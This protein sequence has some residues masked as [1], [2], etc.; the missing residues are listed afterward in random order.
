MDLLLVGAGHAHLYVVKHAAELLAAGYRVTLLSPR[1]FH[2]SG[3]ASAAAAGELPA[4][5]GRIDVAALAGHAGVE[6]HDG[7]LADLD[8]ETRTAR[9]GD[10]TELTYDVI[11]LNIGSVVA[12][13]DMTV[14]DAVLRVKPLSALESLGAHLADP[15]LRGAAR[16]TVVGGGSSGV[17][18][19]AQLACHPAVSQVRLVEAGRRLTPELPEGAGRR[20]ERLMG[21]RGVEVRTG[22]AITHLGERVARRTDGSELDHDLA[23]LATGLAAPPLVEELDLGSR[24]GIPVRATLLHRAHDDLYAAGDCAHFLPRRLPRVGV[25]GVRQGPVLHASLLARRAGDPLPTYQPQA[26]AL[27]VLDL[28]Q[29]LGLAARG[30]RWWLGRSALWLKRRIDRR[31]LARYRTT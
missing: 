17:E 3:V 20:L 11:S 7:V 1:T 26:K 22:C 14:D 31:W 15:R 25:H 12:P 13:P 19:A 10:G 27:A 28:G 18:L 5:T 30:D 6:H 21:K 16:V 9:A 23:I 4:D 2:Y 29:G 8:L 24:N